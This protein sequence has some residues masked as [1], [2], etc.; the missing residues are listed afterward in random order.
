MLESKL[1]KQKRRKGVYG[2]LI[3]T[4]N[5][6]FIDDLNMPSRERFGAQ[7]PLEL[8]RQWFA[9]GGWYDRRSLECNRIVDIAFTACAGVGRTPLSSR[10]LRFF[11]VVHLNDMDAPTLLSVVL[12]IL[13]WG[14]Q[15]CVDKVKFL[16][17]SLSEL[18]VSVNDAVQR[19]FLPLPAKSHYLFNLRD[20]MKVVQGLLAVPAELY[21]AA[22]GTEQLRNQL[23]R[24][25]MHETQRVYADRLVGEEDKRAFFD[26]I[27]LA[28]VERVYKFQ[29]DT[30]AQVLATTSGGQYPL[31]F[32]NFLPPQKQY[33]EVENV[34]TALAAAQ[35]SMAAYFAQTQ[36]QRGKGRAVPTLVLFEDALR[37]LCRLTRI[38][39]QP[40]GNALLVGL[41]GAGT[42]TLTRLATF[43]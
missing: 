9:H 23:L 33:Q 17:R 8:L 5:V 15:A 43:M 20:L 30:R 40:F 26:D 25:F 1:E 24:L 10:L 7:P 11:N 21:A 27:L 14:F 31:L 3:G 16:S 41:G 34:A 18:A 39:A 6:I 2:P 4:T 38:L 42:R 28:Q 36:Q 32:C 22:A 12:K 29:G 13:D 35:D 37:M 19:R